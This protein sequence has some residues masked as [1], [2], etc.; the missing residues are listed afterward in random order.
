MAIRPAEYTG[1]REVQALQY[2]QSLLTRLAEGKTVKCTGQ[3]QKEAADILKEVADE[4]L[5]EL[6]SM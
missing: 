5:H 3:Y 4:G 6:Y 1:E 2:V